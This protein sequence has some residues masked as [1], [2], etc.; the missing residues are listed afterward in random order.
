[1]SFSYRSISVHVVAPG[2]KIV[3]KKEENQYDE[4]AWQIV[5]VIQGETMFF[6]AEYSTAIENVRKMS[7]THCHISYP[8]SLA[9]N[10][11]EAVLFKTWH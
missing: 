11:P 3:E 9:D 2:L 6:V 5:K 10:D 1:V 8:N 4:T 7:R